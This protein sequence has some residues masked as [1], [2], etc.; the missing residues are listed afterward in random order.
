M[1]KP[2]EDDMGTVMRMA[3]RTMEL[4]SGKTIT[5]YAVAVHETQDPKKASNWIR[6]F[7]T[8][9]EVE[10]LKNV[11]VATKKSSGI[12]SCQLFSLGKNVER[13][14]ICCL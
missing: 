9:E 3:K 14:N 5:L 4:D 13:R 11:V 7:A 12:H 1:S 6:L 10:L 2:T 8:G